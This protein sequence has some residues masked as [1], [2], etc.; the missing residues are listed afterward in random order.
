M[1]NAAELPL[2][3]RLEEIQTSGSDVE[4]GLSSSVMS[5]NIISTHRKRMPT[6]GSVKPAL[7]F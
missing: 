7:K 1:P 2:A 3:C 5:N 4:A 6:A